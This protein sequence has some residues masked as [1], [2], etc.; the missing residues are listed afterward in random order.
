MV[1]K[2][3]IIA[4]GVIWMTVGG[5]HALALGQ[6]AGACSRQPVMLVLVHNYASVP[7]EVLRDA[8]AYTSRIYKQTGVTIQ[9]LETWTWQARRT[10]GT[11]YRRLDDARGGAAKSSGRS[12]TRRRRGTGGGGGA[13]RV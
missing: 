11:V 3:H 2:R 4:A 13:A 7:L 8:Q 9:W 6:K 12:S 1:D 10:L 5:A